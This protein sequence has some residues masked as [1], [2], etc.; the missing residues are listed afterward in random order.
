[1]FTGTVAYGRFGFAVAN[2]GDLDAD[3]H[4][5]MILSA[6]HSSQADVEFGC[7]CRCGNRSTLRKKG[8]LG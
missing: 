6:S 3:G 1:M 8:R 5:G 7:C 4:E 2:V